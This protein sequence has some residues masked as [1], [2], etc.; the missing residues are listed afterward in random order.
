M[1]RE[2]LLENVTALLAD[3]GFL[4]S[5]RC[6]V[7]PRG[8]DLAARS[9]ED[10]LLV[11]V[12]GNVD[13]FDAATGGEM[14][15]LG[16]YLS[17]TPLVVGLRTRDEDLKPGV[18]YFR[19]G[20]PAIH[21]DTLYDLLLEGVPPLIYA[22]PGGLYVNID[23]DLVADERRERGWSLGR[24]AEELGVSRRTVAKYEDGMNASVE[25]AVKLEEV[26][27]EPFSDPV[28]VMEGAEEV[29]DGEPDPDEPEP[30]GDPETERVH[31]VLSA[32]G[33]VVHPT[34]QA[35]FDTVG[36]DDARVE[37]TLL[38]TQASLTRA[39]E[40]RAKLMASIGRV[41]QARAV[42]FAADDADRESVDGTAV[43]GRSE[44]SETDDPERLR[45]LI[46]ERSEEPQE[47]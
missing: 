9:G 4:T 26:F 2:A 24:L 3:A 43:V 33:F 39:G 44:L 22:A 18:V 25:V 17:G 37:F 20:V 13:A 8:F 21:P 32:A 12:L 29:R 30:S 23:G 1:S 16:R 42:F 34:E 28:S 27:D 14:R 10:L 46:R 40:K 7:R 38:S 19:H 6:A 41:T 36:E 15:R 35:P 11:K 5:E 31:A 47:A 45:D